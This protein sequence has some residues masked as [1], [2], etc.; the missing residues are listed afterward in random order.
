MTLADARTSIFATAVRESAPALVLIHGSERLAVH[1]GTVAARL[2][3]AFR[4]I[5]IDMPVMD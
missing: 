3:D 1:L 2:S 5:T 4:I